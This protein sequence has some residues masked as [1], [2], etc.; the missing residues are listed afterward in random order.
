[1]YLGGDGVVPIWACERER[2]LGGLP[3][4]QGGWGPSAM[5]SRTMQNAA[6]RMVRRCDLQARVRALFVAD[7]MC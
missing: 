1:M 7:S 6:K 3:C 2:G 4:R 5:A